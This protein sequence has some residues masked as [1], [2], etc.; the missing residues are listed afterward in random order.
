MEN[1]SRKSSLFLR[2]QRAYALREPARLGTGP[3]S[4]RPHPN[5]ALRLIQVVNSLV[6]PSRQR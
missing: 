2:K 6:S 3:A 4:F 5:T 1:D